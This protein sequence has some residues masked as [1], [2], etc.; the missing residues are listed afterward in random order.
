MATSLSA[1]V[2]RRQRSAVPVRRREADV[3]VIVNNTFRRMLRRADIAPGR[4]QRPRIHDLRH[5]FA[6]RVLEQCGA[7]RGKVARR[8]VAL[9]PIWGTRTRY[10]YWYLQATPV[11]M[12]VI[13]SAEE[14]MV[15]RDGPHDAACPS[16]HQLLARLHAPSAR[17]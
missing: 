15:G 5:S 8:F 3:P 9:S 4:S 13:A 2:R 1:G 6:T 14:L 12:T 16:Y 11:M 17:L 7:G 10:T